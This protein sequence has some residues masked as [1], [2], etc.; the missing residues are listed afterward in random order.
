MTG[1]TTDM[2]GDACRIFLG[3]AYPG[4]ADTVPEPRRRYAQ[5]PP[6]EDL[7]DYHARAPLPPS[8]FQVLTDPD[9]DVRAYAVRLGCAHF[10]HLKLKAQRLSHHGAP[11][12]VFAVDTH[13]AFAPDSTRPLM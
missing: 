12:W 13:D 5:L 2:L 10:P 3:L 6:G 8:G 9:G 1:L 7:A 11:V 4:G